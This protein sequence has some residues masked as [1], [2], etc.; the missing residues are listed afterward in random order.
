[1][2][3]SSSHPSPVVQAVAAEEQEEEQ[4]EVLDP[5]EEMEVVTVEM[6]EEMETVEMVEME[7][8]EVTEVTVELQRYTHLIPT[9]GSS[10]DGLSLLDQEPKLHLHISAVIQPEFGITAE[11]QETMKLH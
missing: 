3:E 11:T 6:E 7:M 8:E 4:E 2:T 5:E 10:L 1:M 9:V